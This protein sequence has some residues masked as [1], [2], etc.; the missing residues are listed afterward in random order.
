VIFYKI[1]FY[2][3]GRPGLSRVPSILAVLSLCSRLNGP[4]R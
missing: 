1:E 4:S 3:V 2:L